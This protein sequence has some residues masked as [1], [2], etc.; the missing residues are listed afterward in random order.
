METVPI[1]NFQI[2]SLKGSKTFRLEITHL[3]DDSSLAPQCGIISK[4]EGKKICIVSGQ[5]GN[6]WNGIYTSQKIFKEIRPEEV[7]GTIIVI[8]VANPLA[9]NEKSRVSTIDNIDLNRTYLKG[10]YRKP[11]EILGKMLFEKIFSQVDFLIDIHGGGAGEYKPHVAIT[12][13]NRA[14][15][16]SKFLFSD[17]FVEEKTEGSLA[18]A[19]P[20]SGTDCFTIEAGRQRNLNPSYISQI[21]KGLRNFLKETDTLRGDSE[22]FKGDIFRRKFEVGSP[23]SGFFDP[24]VE[25]GNHIEE[26]ETLGRVE[27]LFKGSEA[28]RS[29]TSGKVLYLRRE[30]A[31]SQGENLTHILR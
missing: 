6:E 9:F 26:E 19:C 27:R 20:E 12:N 31:V 24:D 3:S 13:E 8:P 15:L 1:N 14:D 2:D 23:N 17:I 22:D 5:H 30:G 4:G 11:T 7:K 16:S 10:R 29:P 21:T 28:V 18:A 25:L